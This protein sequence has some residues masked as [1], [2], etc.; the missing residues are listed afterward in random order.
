MYIPVYH[1]NTGTPWLALYDRHIDECFPPA[2]VYNWGG[3]DV[4]SSAGEDWEWQIKRR[5]SYITSCICLELYFLTVECNASQKPRN[6]KTSPSSLNSFVSFYTF[7]FQRYVLQPHPNITR[8]LYP[9]LTPSIPPCVLLG[10]I[11]CLIVGVSVHQA[12]EHLP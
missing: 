8:L 12:R 4:I 6:F 3:R 11:S 2:E 9:S 1:T 10:F 7:F 5:T